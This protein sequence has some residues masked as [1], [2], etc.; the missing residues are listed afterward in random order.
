MPLPALTID[1]ITTAQRV[2]EALREKLLAG[3]IRPGTVLREALISESVGVARSTV[4]EALQILAGEGLLTRSVHRGMS[5]KRL[6]GAELADLFQ[7]RQVLELA[8]V[9][10]SPAA[11]RQSRDRFAALA[12]DLSEPADRGD[13]MG[14]ADSD[15]LF[16]RELVGFLGCQRLNA[17]FA[18]IA[19]DLRLV[20]NALDRSDD[21]LRA[22]AASHQGFAALLLSGDIEVAQSDLKQQLEIAH[23]EMHEIVSREA[24]EGN[25]AVGPPVASAD[26]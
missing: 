10:A 24:G 6:S 17:C 22:Q 9:A 23:A 26:G 3:E 19:A 18:Q 13:W 21:N 2:A 16:H 1:R 20:I 14:F 11:P 15:A 8:A 4:R 5:V 25:A 7:A 12:A